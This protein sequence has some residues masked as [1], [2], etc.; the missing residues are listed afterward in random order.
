M[1]TY[2]EGSS[3]QCS[4]HWLLLFYRCQQTVDVIKN[5]SR[6]SGNVRKKEKICLS[7][8]N[9]RDQYRVFHLI[10]IY[11]LICSFVV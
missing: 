1:W 11:G 9:D 2:S 6:I 10:L 8:G 7:P 5:V 3:N 4:G